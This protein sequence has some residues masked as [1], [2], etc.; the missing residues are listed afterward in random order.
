MESGSCQPLPSGNYVM[1]P[2]KQPIYQMNAD[3]PGDIFL[4]VFVWLKLWTERI[5][6]A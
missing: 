2:N 5:M 4:N 3:S 1:A 6:Y